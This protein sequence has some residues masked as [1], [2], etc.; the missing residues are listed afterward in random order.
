VV[1]QYSG[2]LGKVGNCQVGV[3]LAYGGSRG[4]VAWGLGL[5]PED[6]VSRTLGAGYQM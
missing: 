2:T 4:D 3:F 6:R 1:R 5:H